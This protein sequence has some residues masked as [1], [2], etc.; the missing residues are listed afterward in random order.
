MQRVRQMTVRVAGVNKEMELIRE[1]R[2]V[3][4]RML[5]HH[6]MEG[7]PLG[8]EV[9]NWLLRYGGWFPD[10]QV[11]YGD[12]SSTPPDTGVDGPCSEI[13]EGLHEAE[14]IIL[15]NGRTA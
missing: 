6:Y 8:E 5:A 13:E 11:L 15:L 10:P 7:H 4:R 12:G 3:L 2:V 14:L 9:E 1:S